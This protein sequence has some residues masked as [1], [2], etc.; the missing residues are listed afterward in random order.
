MNKNQSVRDHSDGDY[1]TVP[2]PGEWGGIGR[3]L[4]SERVIR[5]SDV[6]PEYVSEEVIFD[7]MDMLILQS[8]E[9]QEEAQ[10]STKV[11]WENLRSRNSKEA[12][13]TKDT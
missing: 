12:S 11:L 9:S 5:W 13:L 3:E 4:K 8:R 6:L 2:V 7:V 10:V 1:G